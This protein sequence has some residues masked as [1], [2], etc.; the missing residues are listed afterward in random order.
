MQYEWAISVTAMFPLTQIPKI[1]T[2][3]RPNDFG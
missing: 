3:I 1:Q 2:G